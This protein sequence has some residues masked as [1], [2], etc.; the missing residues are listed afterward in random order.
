MLDLIIIII[1]LDFL[2]IILGLIFFSI[3]DHSLCDNINSHITVNVKF[4]VYPH[5]L[6]DLVGVNVL[7]LLKDLVLV[8]SDVDHFM[9]V[10]TF[11][12]VFGHLVV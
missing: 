7:V 9:D 11:D 1:L 4:H 2:L 10:Q 6:R 5:L 3:L 8:G 12:H